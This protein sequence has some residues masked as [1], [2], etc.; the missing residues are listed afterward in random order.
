MK[1]LLIFWMLCVTPLFAN[2]WR[3]LDGTRYVENESNDG[4]SFHAKR[5]RST[6][7]FRLYYVDAPETDTRYPDRVA[8]Q[9]TYFGLSSE[10]AVKGGKQAAK[11][12]EK[13]LAGQ[14]LEVHT[15]YE[16][17]RGASD[18]K[19]YYAMV[20][21]GDRWLSEWLVEQGWA[22]VYG[23]SREL[24]NGTSERLYWSRLRKLERE[25]KKAKRGLWG[26]ADGG[27]PAGGEGEPVTIRLDRQT[28]V[29]SKDPP[30]RMVGQLPQGWE[31][32][33]GGATRTGFR[34]VSFTS[35]GGSSF[36]GEIQI[37][38]LPRN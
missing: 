17:A 16:N 36:T 33:L 7:I 23:R 2:S 30:H 1:G 9:A 25:A 15:R 37:L 13:L 21:V 32:Q 35:P 11:A 19:R 18:K 12:V 6:Y 20:R 10:Q 8:E 34:E 28:P 5:N 24:P 38:Y 14:D 3:E 4:D 27:L 31:V 26:M 22:R 29:F